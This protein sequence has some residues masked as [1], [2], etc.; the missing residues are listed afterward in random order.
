MKPQNLQKQVN[1]KRSLW[2]QAHPDLREQAAAR[3]ASGACPSSNQAAVPSSSSSA[4]A[5]TPAGE[6]HN[7]EADFDKLFSL[8]LGYCQSFSKALPVPAK[9]LEGH[10]RAEAD[11]L[12]E[13]MSSLHNPL[14]T[15]VGSREVAA[16][17]VDDNAR[18]YFLVR[19]ILQ[20]MV[21]SVFSSDGWEGFSQEIRAEMKSLDKRLAGGKD[22]PIV[23]PHE[24]QAIV[25]RKAALVSRILASTRA[26]TFK[27]TRKTSH[28]ERLY[29]MVAPFVPVANRARALRDLNGIVAVAFDLSAKL[30]LSR[31]TFLFLFNDP[32]TKFS[33]GSQQAVIENDNQMEGKSIE[34]WRVK[35]T[36]TPTVT[37]RDDREMTIRVKQILK[38]KVLVH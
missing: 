23:K 6:T 36:V 10:V 18:P 12:W 2:M 32:A 19:L 38:A 30:W 22:I 29:H 28:M 24:R 4:P 20:H 17:L 3:A 14:D 31:M 5:P 9:H 26:E 34:T 21:K 11:G 1:G 33:P 35:L 8:V 37:L 16:L 13:F 15:R 25:D 7:W 27:A